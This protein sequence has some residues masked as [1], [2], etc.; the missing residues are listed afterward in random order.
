MSKGLSSRCR[1]EEGPYAGRV[2]PLMRL[3][4]SR[5]DCTLT[6]LF[7]FEKTGGRYNQTACVRPL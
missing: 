7:D 3:T 4:E 2:E 5:P 6:G 1:N